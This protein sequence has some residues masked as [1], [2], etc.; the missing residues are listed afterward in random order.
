MLSCTG[1][2]FVYI[3]FQFWE[4]WSQTRVSFYA[5][6]SSYLLKTWK[7]IVLTCFTKMI[8]EPSSVI[9][10]ICMTNV[11]YERGIIVLPFLDI[12]FV[13][14]LFV[15]QRFE[16]KSGFPSFF[17]THTVYC[18]QIMHL[19]GWV[20]LSINEI[21]IHAYIHNLNQHKM[22]FVYFPT[23]IDCIAQKSNYF[24]LPKSWEN[25]LN[26]GINFN[27]YGFLL[28]NK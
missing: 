1:I 16:I 6:Q 23:S 19:C 10:S 17:F 9:Q 14:L 21:C 24:S 22:N 5:T 11:S 28:K 7:K 27:L 26:N 2:I 3:F 15:F 25:M 13:I 18:V 12:S 20:N 4:I 8:A